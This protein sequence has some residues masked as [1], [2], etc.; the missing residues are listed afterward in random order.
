MRGRK[1]VQDDLEMVVVGADVE[2]LYPSLTDI[3][4][5]EIC[6]EAVMASKVKFENINYQRAGMYVA[7]N[8]FK[9]DQ[10]LSPL[11]RIL[12]RRNSKGVVRPGMTSNLEDTRPSCRW[13]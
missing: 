4:V 13:R 11:W 6:Y 8:M 10:R 9:T 2:A 3:E 7:M 1:E 12:P 5:A